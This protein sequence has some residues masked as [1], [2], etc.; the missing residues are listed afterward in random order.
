M[1]ENETLEPLFARAVAAIDGGDESTLERL[2]GAHPDLVVRRAEYGSGYFANP[3][4]LWFVAGNPVRHT[5][6]PPNIGRL[7]QKIIDAVRTHAADTLPV[8]LDYALDLVCSGRIP[9]ES[10]VQRELIGILVDAGASPDCTTS[11]LAHREWDAAERLLQRGARLT[12]PV[13]AALRSVGDVTRL[14]PLSASQER[15]IALIAAALAGRVEVV[16]LLVDADIDLNAFGPDG[17]HPH[18]TALHQ[19]VYSGSL[20]VV[21][22][23]VEAG[24]DLQIS[25]RIYGATALGWAEH[26]ERTEIAAYLRSRGAVN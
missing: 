14:L 6:L 15:Q 9:R 11:A 19:A 25:D 1:S 13:A 16:R 24:A 21:R 2:I 17:F 3:Y 20:D 12:L 10:G 23:L 4:L 22:V 18:A 7:T 8:Q 26:L 5:T